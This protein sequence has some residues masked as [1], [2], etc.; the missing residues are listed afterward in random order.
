MHVYVWRVNN[1]IGCFISCIW[2]SFVFMFPFFWVCVC[3]EFVM[4]LYGVQLN[5]CNCAPSV[6]IA[7]Y[8]YIG[9]C[10]VCVCNV[11][12]ICLQC[13][14]NVFAMRGLCVCTLNNLY[15]A[16]LLRQFLVRIVY[17]VFLFCIYVYIVCNMRVIWT[18]VILLCQF[19]LLIICFFYV[20]IM[21]LYFVYDVFT[22]CLQCVCVW[23]VY[24]GHL[25]CCSVAL[26]V[27]VA[28]HL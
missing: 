11:F 3:N 5:A 4:Y 8:S 15:F 12:V 7:N 18:V 20:F 26:L 28:N 24:I 23:C 10:L 14:C 16:I 21:C 2:Y 27:Y 9:I 1:C 13:V 6:Y 17:V 22:M 19:P 25:Y